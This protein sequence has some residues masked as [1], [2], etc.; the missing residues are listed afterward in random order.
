MSSNRALNIA[1]SSALLPAAAMRPIGMGFSSP[2]MTKRSPRR[3]SWTI[4]GA[5]SLKR[6]SMRSTYVPGGSVT[7]ESAEM[8]FMVESPGPG[9]VAVRDRQLVGGEERDD[10][11]PGGRDDDFLLDAGG[12]HAVAGRAVR[13]DGEHHPRLQLHRIVEGVQPADDRPLVEAKADAVAE[14]EPE[15]GHL[16]LEADVRR[17]REGAGDLVGRDAGLDE[18]DRLV[19]PLAGLLV[20]REL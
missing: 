17:L 6:R 13:L 3:A 14:V 18:R 9:L 4:R 11:C 2:S 20:R 8:G 12:G 5:R 1:S 16:R 10:L 15:G 19:H 7:C